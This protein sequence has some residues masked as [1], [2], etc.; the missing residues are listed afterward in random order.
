MKLKTIFLA[1]LWLTTLAAHAATD[2][3]GKMEA[4]RGKVPGSYNFWI[5]TP[6]E[7]EAEGRGVGLYIS[8]GRPMAFITNLKPIAHLIDGYITTN[9]AYCVVGDTV[10]SRHPMDPDDVATVLADAIDNHYPVVVDG[11]RTIV[12]Y[13]NSD[14]V[15]RIYVKGLGVD[16]LDYS[17]T[18]KDLGTEGILELSPFM[19]RAQE[20]AL[21]PRLRHVTSGRWHPEFTDFTRQ[22]VDK[23][24]GLREMAGFLH[25]DISQTMAFG[26]GGN[27]IA[28]L[29]AAG[30]GVAMGNSA[31]DVK[32]AADFVTTDVDNHGIAHALRHYKIID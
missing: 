22:G 2:G 1:L 32:A 12:V 31:D 25:L 5:F 3:Q 18:L 15:D 21:S 23:A 6:E 28:I 29:S 9:G 20:A 27:D 24:L 14:L 11:E 16:V 26:D 30:I 10:V 4:M 19:T 17:L 13:N 7:Y 8:T